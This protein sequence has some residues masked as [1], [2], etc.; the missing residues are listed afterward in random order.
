MSTPPFEAPPAG[1]IPNSAGRSD[2]TWMVALLCA[3]LLG[4]GLAWLADV[5][6]L[7]SCH[8]SVG[9]VAAITVYL[10][11]RRER[12]STASTGGFT[13]AVLMCLSV[14]SAA[15]RMAAGA[16]EAGRASDPNA[17]EMLP[18]NLAAVFAG[19]GYACPSSLLGVGVVLLLTRTLRVGN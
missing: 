17:A 2:P 4:M 18:A 7:S 11:R 3:P 1:A 15:V 5:G 12:W 9:A 6:F 13:L 19:C 16:T 10:M 8:A 14:P